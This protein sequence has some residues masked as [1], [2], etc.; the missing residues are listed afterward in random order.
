MFLHAGEGAAGDVVDEEAADDGIRER[1]K[2]GDAEPEIVND[3]NF[4][5]IR[6]FLERPDD[7][8]A[9]GEG[10]EMA[11]ADFAALAVDPLLGDPGNRDAGT[12]GGH[13]DDVPLRGFLEIMNVA[14]MRQ[15]LRPLRE[16]GG[17]LEDGLPRGAHE[18]GGGGEHGEIANC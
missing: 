1:G 6:S 3:C 7:L 13:F 18:D 11:K 9:F 5:A 12:D 15:N 14:V 8:H 4:N 17:G 10:L 16:V 2:G